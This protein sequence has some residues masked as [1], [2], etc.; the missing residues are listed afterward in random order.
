MTFSVHQSDQQTETSE[1]SPIR[2]ALVTGAAKGIGRALALSLADSGHN[3]AVHYRS[4]ATQAAEVVEA[5]RSAGGIAH[6]FQADLTNDTAA[7]DLV[8]SV[9]DVLGGVHVVIN[10]VGNF[11]IGPLASYPLAS[12]RDMFASNLDSTF[13]VCQSALVPMRAQHYGRIV[14]F[15]F[16]GT[17]QLA[18]RPQSVA[19]T[20]AKTGVTLLTKAI[21]LSEIAHGITAN[22][23][24]PGIIENS[25]GD[26]PPIPAGRLGTFN[27][28][29]A[30]VRYFVS[31]E[32]NYVTGQTL[33]IA[34]GWHL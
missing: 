28:V 14:N 24:A 10:N 21:A 34:G 23:I 12:W 4:S 13:A 26:L 11:A 19:Y 2:V 5:V 17:N 22:V 8:Q 9:V 15:G 33:E 18:A 29:C 32:A 30:A 27:D 1:A 6:A 16:A 31:D 3:V 7:R 25:V 20:I